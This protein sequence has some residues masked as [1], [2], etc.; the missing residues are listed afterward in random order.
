MNN[1][2]PDYL[3]CH[4]AYIF[5]DSNGAMKLKSQFVKKILSKM[6]RL[7]IYILL[8]LLPGLLLSAPLI[9]SGIEYY[10]IS[11]NSEQQIRHNLNAKTP[12][13]FKGKKYDAYTK[14]N[15]RWNFWWSESQNSCAISKVTVKL[16]VDQTLPKLIQSD[17]LTQSLSHQ[18]ETYYQALLEHE[19]GHKSLGLDAANEIEHAIK[20]L[21]A[22]SS[23]KTLE[24]KANQLGHTIIKKYIKLEKDYD[25]RTNYGMNE[26]AI[27]P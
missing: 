2:P 24:S 10:E 21:S 23:C 22:Q 13:L 3:K 12:V 11:G 26:G 5:E 4:S 1:N 6:N 7:I 20:N 9:S 17:S 18:W 8:F 25:K 14:W 19:E 15:V 27:F 16:D